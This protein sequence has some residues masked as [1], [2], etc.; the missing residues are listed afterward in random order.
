MHATFL[1]EPNESQNKKKCI[2]IDH[3]RFNKK[4]VSDGMFSTIDNQK[5][6]FLSPKGRNSLI[7]ILSVTEEKAKYI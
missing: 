7:K 4:A 5:V 3:Q 2:E 1:I 6:C